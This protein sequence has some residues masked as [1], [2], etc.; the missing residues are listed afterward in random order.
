[1]KRQEQLRSA[2]AKVGYSV[3]ATTDPFLA[4]GKFFENA[5]AA[6][7]L[8][9]NAQDVGAPALNAFNRLADNAK[10]DEVAIGAAT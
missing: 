1:M 7:G 2:L 6:E 3:T 9:I 8:L 5:Q 10:T 4:V